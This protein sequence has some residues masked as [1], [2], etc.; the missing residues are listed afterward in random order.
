MPGVY[1]CLNCSMEGMPADTVPFGPCG[2]SG[3]MPGMGL[4]GLVCP[5]DALPLFLTRAAQEP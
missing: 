3:P 1:I 4:S 5:R 2:S